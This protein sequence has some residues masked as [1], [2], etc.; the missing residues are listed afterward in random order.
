MNYW[1]AFKW[2]W[3]ILGTFLGLGI[4]MMIGAGRWEFYPVFTTL[5]A[6]FC[7]GMSIDAREHEQKVKRK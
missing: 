6:G 1:T 4:G 5:V 3:R 2:L 7:I